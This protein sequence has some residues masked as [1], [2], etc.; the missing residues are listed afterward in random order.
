MCPAS[1]NTASPQS[2]HC[3]LCD[4]PVTIKLMPCGHSVICGDCSKRATKCPSCQVWCTYSIIWPLPQRCMSNLIQSTCRTNS[5]QHA[6]G[7]H[8][9]CTNCSAQLCIKFNYVF[10]ADLLSCGSSPP[11]L[12]W[13]WFHGEEV[14]DPGHASAEGLHCGAVSSFFFF[15]LIITYCR[16]VLMKWKSLLWTN[17]SVL[18]LLKSWIKCSIAQ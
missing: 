5:M 11:Y 14:C 13:V 15:F 9:C 1:E 4:A 7:E 6:W 8:C 16:V 3:M 10:S 17:N 12:P 18:R 2:Q